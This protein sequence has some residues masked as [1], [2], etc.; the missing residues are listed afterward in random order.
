MYLK[1]KQEELQGN[2]EHKEKIAARAREHEIRMQKFILELCQQA[3]I[4]EIT[5]PPP[6]LQ[7]TCTQ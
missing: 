6:Y 4:K 7:L 3:R 1:F 5:P 2:R